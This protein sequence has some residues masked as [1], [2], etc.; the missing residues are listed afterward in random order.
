MSNALQIIEEIGDFLDKFSL[1]KNKLS[2]QDLIDFIEKKWQE[3][4]DGKYTIH[5]GYI[6]MHRMI[7]EYIRAKDFDNM[8]R[9]LDMS[10]LHSSSKKDEAY[11]GNYYK[12]QC[13]LDC[14]NE[15]KALEYLNLCYAENPGYIFTRAPFCYEFFN[16]HLPNP[17]ELPKNDKEDEDES[18]YIELKEWQSFF[19][20]QKSTL[21]YEILKKDFE[22]AKKLNERHKNG[23]EY[24]QKNQMKVLDSILN[25][26]LIQYPALQARYGYPE[27]DKPDFMPDLKDIKGFAALLSPTVM[28]VISVYKDE[29]PYIGY[30]FSC[31]WD[32][33]HGLG[34][35]TYKDRVVKIGDAEIAFSMMGVKDDLKQDKQNNT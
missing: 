25:E 27:E 11:V 28:Y 13:C 14:G 21:C 17:R 16:K 30:S 4:D 35:M 12:G 31:S 20:E 22:N 8:M 1:K 23:L 3:A 5:S 24:L 19:G 9:W 7:N 2:K 6:Y 26:L 10:D 33:E 18:R 15:E 34:V 32:R 29:F